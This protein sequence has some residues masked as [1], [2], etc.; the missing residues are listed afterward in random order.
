MLFSLTISYIFIAGSIF[1]CLNCGYIYNADLSAIPEASLQRALASVIDSYST[2]E[3]CRTA[4]EEADSL[5]SQCTCDTKGK[6]PACVVYDGDFV[7]VA[8]FVA[9][10]LF[11]KLISI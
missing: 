10:T 11:M 6:I 1:S 9:G 7:F 4:A 5:R 2:T 3:E 8:N